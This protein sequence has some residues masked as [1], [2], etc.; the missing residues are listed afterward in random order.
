L[1]HGTTEIE[2]I[3]RKVI[4]ELADLPLAPWRPRRLTRRERAMRTLGRAWRRVGSSG[5]IR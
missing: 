4:G 5:R 1:V 3:R 2:R